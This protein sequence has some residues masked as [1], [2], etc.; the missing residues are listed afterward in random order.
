MSFTAI[1]EIRF[2]LCGGQKTFD[3]WSRKYLGFCG[4]FY[5]LKVLTTQIVQVVVPQTGST[6]EQWLASHSKEATGGVATQALWCGVC[7][8]FLRL[9]RFSGGFSGGSLE[10]LCRFSGE[11]SR[12]S[13]EVLRLLPRSK[14][15]HFTL[16]GN[17]KLFRRLECECGRWFCLSVLVWCLIQCVNQPLPQG[18][19]WQ[20][21]FVIIRYPWLDAFFFFVPGELL[22]RVADFFHLWFWIFFLFCKPFSRQVAHVSTFCVNQPRLGSYWPLGWSPR[23]AKWAGMNLMRL[24]AMY[25]FPL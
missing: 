8:F 4:G 21:T 11:F 19:T 15:M 3:Q 2:S 16:K 18:R 5:A 25:T 22:F 17:C 6:M 13:L 7:M 9:C 14:D 23:P 24:Q 12:G 1:L 10:V 20:S